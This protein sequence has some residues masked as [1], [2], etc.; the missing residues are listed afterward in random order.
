MYGLIMIMSKQ[1][2]HC[3]VKQARKILFKAFTIGKRKTKSV[4][5][6]TKTKS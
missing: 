6:F 3:T 4:L 2:L 5:N 1:K